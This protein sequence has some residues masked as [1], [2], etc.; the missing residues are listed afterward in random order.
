VK[1]TLCVTI[2]L[3]ALGLPAVRG[4]D[5][6]PILEKVRAATRT[7]RV[8]RI[9]GRLIHETARPR[10]AQVRLYPAA[11]TFSADL[12]QIRAHAR[13][14]EA[15]YLSVT[16]QLERALLSYEERLQAQDAFELILS[17][18]TNDEGLFEFSRVPEGRWMLL[19]WADTTVP[20]TP[21]KQHTKS[22]DQDRFLQPAPPTTY[23]QRDFWFI[24]V[25]VVG[26]EQREVEL[27]DRNRWTSAISR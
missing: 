17:A 11:S 4:E 21:R 9:S 19:A 22:K 14:S 15:N 3:V 25:D 18:Q 13:D 23:R 2:G 10:T 16:K 6:G 24:S 8:A 20:V 7:D 5:L 26:G 12:E 1:L 27:T